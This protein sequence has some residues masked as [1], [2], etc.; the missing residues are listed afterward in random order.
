VRSTALGIGAVFLAGLDASAF[1]LVDD[2][3]LSVISAGL[4]ARPPG[5]MPT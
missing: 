4:L 5:R 1:T 3:Q 2:A